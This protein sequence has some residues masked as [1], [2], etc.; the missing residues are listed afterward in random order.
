MTVL[1]VVL[2][3]TTFVV[4]V[5]NVA[6]II[7][8]IVVSAAAAVLGFRK[9]PGAGA[10]LPLG[11][12]IPILAVLAAASQLLSLRPSALVTGFALT[13]LGGVLYLARRIPRGGAGTQ[14]HASAQINTLN[15]PLMKAARRAKPPLPDRPPHRGR[16]RLPPEA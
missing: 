15:T 2:R 12:V 1:L 10:R 16:R 4:S 11:P 3:D 7:A 6:A 14:G 8:M 9:W 5:A 13:G